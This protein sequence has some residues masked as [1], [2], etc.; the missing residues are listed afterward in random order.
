MTSAVPLEALCDLLRRAAK[1]EIMPRFRN[2]GEGQVRAKSEAS[3]LVTEA[4]ESAERFMRGEIGD[5]VPGALFIGEESV[6]AD[7][8]LLGRLKDAETAIIVD[9]VDGTY[10]FAA[11][12][13]LFGV[14]LSM[15]RNG[16]TVAGIIY[17][18]VGDDW[19]VA[20]KGA[21]AFRITPDGSRSRLAVAEPLPLEQMVG[22]ASIGFLFGNQ[23][24]Q[25][26]SN[27][28]RARSFFNYRCAAHEYR[29]LS[30][31]VTQFTIYNKLMPWDHLAG[32]LIHQE[33]G[34]YAAKFDG[35]PYLP[36]DTDGG[37]IAAVDKESWKLILKEIIERG[38]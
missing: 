7:A 34:G 30:A 28:A 29:V 3:D 12:V 5:I 14:M 15:V 21:G 26:L 32:V 20:E 36:T 35:S 37:L 6:A 4:D 1:A 9:P 23:R 11:G 25:V 18:P 19:F 22:T 8:A 10:N 13:P 17:D 16:E 24:A 31:G 2:L 38:A 27:L 33:A